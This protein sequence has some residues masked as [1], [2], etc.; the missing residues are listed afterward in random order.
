VRNGAVL[1]SHQLGPMRAARGRVVAADVPARAGGSARG[2]ARPTRAAGTRSRERRASPP[3]PD[4]GSREAPAVTA[5]RTRPR[6]A[7]APAEL[8]TAIHRHGAGRSPARHSAAGRSPG[9]HVL[10]AHVLAGRA[11]A[12]RDPAPGEGEAA[13]REAPVHPDAEQTPAEAAALPPGLASPGS[14]ARCRAHAAAVLG[15]RPRH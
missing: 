13:V 2:P 5:G 6:Q 15:A 7:F 4:A 9:G 8:R 10:A 14:T 3:A 12:S 1:R 11:P